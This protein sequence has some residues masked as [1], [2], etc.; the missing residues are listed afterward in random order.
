MFDTLEAPLPRTADAAPPPIEFPI[1]GT[2]QKT[3]HASLTQL[4]AIERAR[5]LAEPAMTAA[6]TADWQ[7]HVMHD[8]YQGGY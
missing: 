7:R 5:A 1:I 8:R 6:Q 3:V 4:V 2:G